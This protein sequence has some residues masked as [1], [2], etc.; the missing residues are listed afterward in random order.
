MTCT[1]KIQEHLIFILDAPIHLFSGTEE[2]TL[3]KFMFTMGPYHLYLTG[4]LQVISLMLLRH[5]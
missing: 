2:T 3:L 4:T 5:F 1:G